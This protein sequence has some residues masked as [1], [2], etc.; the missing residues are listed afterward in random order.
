MNK[1]EQNL[2][3][4]SFYIVFISGAEYK[5]ISV[6]EKLKNWG[7]ERFRDGELEEFLCSKDNRLMVLLMPK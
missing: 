4:H 2:N 5:K 7:E 6:D 3:C 1:F